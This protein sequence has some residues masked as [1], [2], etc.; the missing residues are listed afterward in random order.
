M[1][2]DDAARLSDLA[3]TADGLIPVIAQ[4]AGTG[5]VL[6]MA[7]ANRTALERTLAEKRMWFWS[8]SR[9]TLWRKGETS[10]NEL[11]LR[12]L[13]A[14]CDGDTLLALVEPQGPACHTGEQTCFR[15]GPILSQLGEVIDARSK[16][17]GAP[18]YTRRLLD[19]T[20]LRLKK[21]G[22]EAVELALACRSG[23]TEAVASEAADLLFHVLVA[24]RAAG[25]TERDVLTR[26]LQR[27][28]PARDPERE[29]STSD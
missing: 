2:I 29:A 16:E 1:K 5:E 18:G 25:V 22:E 20:N 12:S 23:E 26:L 13:H 6:M 14:D 19:D 27:R 4:D 24:C 28:Q 3:F 10:G 21:L 7:W 11:R 17:A 8:R 15:T 9:R